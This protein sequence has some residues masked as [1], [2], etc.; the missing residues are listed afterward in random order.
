MKVWTN[1]VKFGISTHL[2]HDQRLARHHLA[3][4]AEHGFELVEL[5]ASRTHFDYHD[6]EAIDRLK[7][8]L[9][10]TGLALHSVHAPIAESLV[11]G[12]WGTA[13]STAHADPTERTRAVHEAETALDVAR[14]I[15]TARCLVVHLGVPVAHVT[16][17]ADNH[18]EAAIRSLDELAERASSLGV[19]VAAELIPNPLS[20]PDAL[21]I[22]LED[23]VDRREVGA[24]MD[25]GHA[26]LMGDPVE[27][28]ETLSGHLIATHV[29]DN[30]GTSDEHLVPFAGTIDWPAC[31]MAL[32]KVGYDGPLT[33]ELANTS[34][35]RD[36]LRQARHARERFERLLG[37]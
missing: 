26:S 19:M 15:E 36:V 30:Q 5:F 3:E 28:V 31:L 34:T 11:R 6:V 20:S 27:A 12:Q 35:P 21:L 10:E 33:M 8:W 4:I 17:P 1:L 23:E 18:R 14:R 37:Y 2:Y 29:H 9:R 24:C 32:Q 16:S 7:E 22:L 25:F 13:Y